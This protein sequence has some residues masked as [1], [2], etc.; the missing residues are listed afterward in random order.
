MVKV[1]VKVLK[2][3]ENLWYF[4]KGV[5]KTFIITIIE[6]FFFETVGAEIC[7]IIYVDQQT[8]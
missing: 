5:A 7:K 6:L 4:L 3:I 8:W 2:V 1:K